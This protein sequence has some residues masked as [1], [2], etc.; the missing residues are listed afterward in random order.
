MSDLEDMRSFVEVVRA[1]GFSP[2][3]RRLGLSKSMVSRRIGRLEAGL[4]TRLL[5]RTTRGVIPTDAGSELFA[6]AERILADYDE[7]REV[8]S[9]QAGDIV[10]RLRVAAPLSFGQRA[11]S[12]IFAEIAAAHPGLDLDVAFS[13]QLVD[14]VADRFDAAVRIGVLADSSLVAR[15]IMPLKRA[16]VAS[17]AYLARAGRPERP[18]D[19][20]Q[21]ECLQFANRLGA[22][23]RFYEGKR[24]VSVRTHGRLTTNNGECLLDWA[25]TGLGI[26]QLPA[27]AAAEAV[28]RGELEVLLPEARMPE[29][30]LHLVRPPGAYV[31]AKVRLLFDVLSKRLASSEVWRR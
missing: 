31:P 30:G 22:D 20:A 13:D 14:L 8:V 9:R 10:G 1:Q 29:L 23:W 4:G 26:A 27:Y 11:L 21:H 12:E 17:P 5:D 7:A 24:P 2:A 19:L 16:I 6:R 18:A 3:A 15:Q 28:A 25:I